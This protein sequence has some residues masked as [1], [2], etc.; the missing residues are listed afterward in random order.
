MSAHRCLSSLAVSALLIAALGL[1]AG[2][3]SDKQPDKFRVY[4]GTYTGGGKSKGIYTFDLDA[5][6]GK[7]SKPVV[8]AETKDPSFVAIHP[9]HKFLYAVGEGGAKGG[10]HAFSIDA[11]TGMLTLINS[12]PSGGAGPCHLIVDPSGN[13][14]LAANYDGGSCCCIPIKSDG[15]LDDPS[16]VMQHKGS[17]VNKA[18][19][20]GPHA[21]SINVDAKNR[22]AFCA[23]LGLDKV[24]VY[25]FDS[26][27]HTLT[28]N[29]PPAFDTAP[30]AGPRHFAFH[31]DGKTAYICGELDM[32]LTACEYDADKGVLTKTQVLPTLPDNA[33]RKGAS[34]AEV[35]VHPSGQF[36]YVSNRG[37]NSIAIF[38]IGAKTRIVTL[39]GHQSKGISTPR[40][41]AIEPTGHYMLVA[42]Q[43]G[44]SVIAFRINQKSGEL[45]PTDSSVDIPSPVCV[46]FLPMTK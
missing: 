3:G 6:T 24:L 32:T 18:R 7:M 28:A 11:K 17:S 4:V 20:E 9:G 15:S 5:K 13:N 29:D 25:R 39:I 19:Q 46:R 22:F 21:H 38:G 43:D 12:Q 2:A 40:N 33:K 8:A 41:F 1:F 30:G 44:H 23:D 10:V 45:T 36:V 14:V 42:N 35:V 37:H 16:A 31:P 26:A 34:T 27:K